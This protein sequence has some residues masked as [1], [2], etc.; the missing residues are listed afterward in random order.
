M[1]VAEGDVLLLEVPP[2]PAGR[3]VDVELRHRLADDFGFRRVEVQQHD[4]AVVLIGHLEGATVHPVTGRRCWRDIVRADEN[5]GFLLHIGQQLLLPLGR[6]DGL[7]QF[8]I[9]LRPG[10][11]E[12]AEIAAALRLAGFRPG[13][14]HGRQ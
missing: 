9:G 13:R 10:L 5:L 8:G 14:S 4:S 12:L 11:I 7:G 1:A 3:P 6:L 2:C